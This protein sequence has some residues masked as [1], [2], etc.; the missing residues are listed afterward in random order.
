MGEYVRVEG[1]RGRVHC[2]TA[3]SGKVRPMVKM[4]LIRAI[5]V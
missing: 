3:V 2:V 5:K 4:G 1:T